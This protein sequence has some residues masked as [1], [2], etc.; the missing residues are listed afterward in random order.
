MIL[1]LLQKQMLDKLVVQLAGHHLAGVQVRRGS[2]HARCARIDGLVER[3]AGTA[4]LRL[5]LLHVG[6]ERTIQRGRDTDMQH[7]A[8]QYE[9]R[10]MET[11][12]LGQMLD[13][14]GQHEA[15]G[16]CA[17]HADSIGQGAMLVEV[18]RDDDDAR[19]GR[20]TAANA[21]RRKNVSR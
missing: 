15:A 7:A 5:C 18:L 14:Y 12:V 16:R 19:R 2:Q 8:A 10:A 3:L 1:A 11:A 21:C 9:Q 4:L 6:A 20:Q 13:Q 17:R